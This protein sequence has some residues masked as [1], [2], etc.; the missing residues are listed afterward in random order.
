MRELAALLVGDP[1]EVWESTGFVVADGAVAVSGVALRLG[2]AEP[3]LSGWELRDGAGGPPTPDHPN[4]VTDIDHVVM[5]TP[6]L[7]ATVDTLVAGGHNLRRIREAGNGVRQ[8]FFRLGPVI[9]EVVGPM[10]QSGLWGITFTVH[11]LDATAAFL[12]DRLGAVKDAVQPGRRI[13][14]L[15][16]SAGS[17]VPIAF[18]SKQ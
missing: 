18:I 17:T 7:D 11:D 2:Q 12:G 9:L 13:A 16:R 5:A 6:D 3:G 14:T 15:A 1:P 10:E 8:A 4:G